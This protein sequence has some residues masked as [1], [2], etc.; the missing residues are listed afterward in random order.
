MRL[1][2]LIALLCAAASLSAQTKKLTIATGLQA[3]I[4]HAEGSKTV[5]VLLPGVETIELDLTQPGATAF[6]IKAADYNFDGYKDF[7]FVGLNVATGIQVYDIFLYHPADKSFEA[8]EYTGGVCEALG[9]V[10]LN[11]GDK[12]LRSSCKANGKTS[13]DVFRWTTPF[14]IELTKSIDNSA[15]KQQE[16]AEEK[17]EKKAEKADTR[18]EIRE[19]KAEKRKDR[20]EEREEKDDDE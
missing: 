15:E 18:K 2:L 16:T 1:L 13:T 7:A 10:R 17:A 20:K 8:L 3:T 9:N 5:Q 11:A 4:N 6:Q 14:A 12:T 19:E